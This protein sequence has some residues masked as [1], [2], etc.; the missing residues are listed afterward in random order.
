MIALNIAVPPA[1]ILEN[2][3]GYQG[4]AR[5]MATYWEPGGDEAMVSDGQISMTGEWEGFLEYTRRCPELREHELGNSDEVAQEWLVI[6]REERK[7]YVAPSREAEKLLRS[8]WPT[9]EPIQL[10]A[11][12]WTELVE[13]TLREMRFHAPTKEQ[14]QEQWNRR[15]SAI[16]ALRAWMNRN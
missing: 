11:D 1:P 9:H 3:L 16:S 5:W 13:R 15:V 7:A 10:S 4:E 2:A 6:D 8:Q 12:E 14:I